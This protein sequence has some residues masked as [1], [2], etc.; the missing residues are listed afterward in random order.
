M[1]GRL[2]KGVIKELIDELNAA[3]TTIETRQKQK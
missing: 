2:K 3:V 1:S